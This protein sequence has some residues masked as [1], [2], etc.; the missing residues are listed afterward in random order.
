MKKRITSV[1]VIAFYYFA[2]YNHETISLVV[3]QG[4]VVELPIVGL[5]LLSM[6]SSSTYAAAG[7]VSD[8]RKGFIFLKGPAED[9]D[10]S[11]GDRDISLHVFKQRLLM[12]RADLIAS[13]CTSIR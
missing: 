4:K 7:Y 1:V 12:C 13:Y 6:A 10:Y 2:F 11:Y 9:L 3:W 8:Q 5:V